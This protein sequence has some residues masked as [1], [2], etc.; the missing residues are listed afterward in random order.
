MAHDHG[1]SAL[2]RR[3]RR[4]VRQWLNTV[5]VR[6]GGTPTPRSLPLVSP[7]RRIILIRLNKRLG[8][9]LFTTPLLRSLAATFPE[10]EID[11]LM[12]GKA[13]AIL[14]REL[15]GVRAVHVSDGGMRRLWLLLRTLRRR[16]FDLAVIPSPSS[17]S[18][19]FGAL[20]CG[21]RQRLGFAGPNQWLRLSHAPALAADEQH[22][23]RIPLTLLRDGLGNT[24]VKLHP[25][26][27]VQPGAAAGAAATRAWHEALG[28]DEQ[29]PVLAFFKQAT[30]DKQLPLEWWQAWRQALQQAPDEP[31]LLEILPGPDAP[32]LAADI[33]GVHLP[34]LDQLA[35]LLRKA[36]VFIAADGGPMHLA[37]A[38]GTPTIGL[39]QHTSPAAYGPL[40]P[41]CLSLQGEGISPGNAARQALE[42]LR[43]SR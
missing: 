20:L 43:E 32:G 19:R 10:A 39:F 12:R 18:D 24:A 38:A 31:R 1:T 34:A 23:G 36:S 21:A 3:M 25:Y 42:L 26:L 30:G 28:D 33:P 15:P 5:L 7:T 16:H 29:R 6:F 13:N 2:I 8:N 11:I 41:N 4:G 40:G 35:A 27:S 37:A 14:L 17:S 22:Q 9:A